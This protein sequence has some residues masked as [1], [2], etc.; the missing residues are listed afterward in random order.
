MKGNN[1][2]WRWWCSDSDKHT[3]LANA[4]TPAAAD[5]HQTARQL[6]AYC[7]HTDRIDTHIKRDNF[8]KSVLVT[9]M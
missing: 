8:L 4:H 6:N 3:L 5:R 7:T 9:E 1:P 2:R